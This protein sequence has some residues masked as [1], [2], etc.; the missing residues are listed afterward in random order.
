VLV[1]VYSGGDHFAH[2]VTI[3]DQYCIVTLRLTKSEVFSST[4]RIILLLKL[5]DQNF[6][7]LK[8]ISILRREIQLPSLPVVRA[9]FGDLHHT[10]DSRKMQNLAVEWEIGIMLSSSSCNVAIGFA[11]FY[12]FI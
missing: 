1:F 11:D 4:F 5:L 2:A 12:D 6:N 9:L 3:G 10:C 8:I 7:L